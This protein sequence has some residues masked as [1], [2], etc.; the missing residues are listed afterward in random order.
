MKKLYLIF[1]LAILSLFSACESFNET[2]Y[3]LYYDS[4]KSA[5]Q[6]K[7]IE[8]REFNDDK[9]N[10]ENPKTISLNVGDKSEIYSVN[11]DIVFLEIMIVAQYSQTQEI[12]FINNYYLTKGEDNLIKLSSLK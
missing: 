11:S 12:Y 9:G 7:R 8:I 1:S 3:Q 10:Y 2:T 6:I 5:N 4:F